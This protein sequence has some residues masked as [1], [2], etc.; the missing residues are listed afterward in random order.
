MTH[1]NPLILIALVT[2]LASAPLLYS[3]DVSVSHFPTG[4]E[5]P[6]SP[7][8]S[9]IRQR[10]T[11]LEFQKYN[12][13][14]IVREVQEFTPHFLGTASSEPSIKELCIEK[15]RLVSKVLCT[16]FEQEKAR[17]SMSARNHDPNKIHQRK[18]ARD[19]ASLMT[20]GNFEELDE[21]SETE[22]KLAIYQIYKSDKSFKK[23]REDLLASKQCLP[24][25]VVTRF[26]MRT[27]EDFPDP[28][29][30]K[31]A[32]KLYS[33]VVECDSEFSYYREIALFRGAMLKIWNNNCESA[34]TQL[35]ELAALKVSRYQTRSLYWLAY[36]AEVSNNPI[37]AEIY[38]NRLTRAN[39]LSYHSI[40]LNGG[41]NKKLFAPLSQT[42]PNIQFRSNSRSELNAY[43]TLI[44]ILQ[45]SG[46]REVTEELLRYVG[47]NL[48][49][50]ED[51][52]R[53]YVA[54]LQNR[55]GNYLGS[56]RTLSKLILNQPNLVTKSTL[57]LYYPSLEF[58]ELWKY[59]GNLN[60]Y[61]VSALIR[62]ESAFNRE[63]RSRVG[64]R[65]L[66]QLMPATAKRF[67]KKITNLGLYDPKTNINLG[68]RY[69][70]KLVERFNG[71]EDL[72]LAAYNAGPNKVD[73]W[74][75]RYPTD[76]K[77][78]FLD[79]IPYSETR[80]Y[81]SLIGRN[82][83]WY[84]SL[85]SSERLTSWKRERSRRGLAS[86]KAPLFADTLD[87]TQDF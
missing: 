18:N 78:L 52:F 54:V 5:L 83:Y 71:N 59:R 38:R 7:L 6:K 70:A 53:L 55:N 21:F 80:N 60:P 8:D 19:L 25:H 31:N 10:Q 42:E 40:V 9:V 49:N 30:I 85:Y 79:L 63:A 11:G 69:L 35:E 3:T 56:F 82:Y 87:A 12:L 4:G 45:E 67:Q 27:E 37:E 34:K 44:E 75:K 64:A 73:E 58:E 77:M 28:E 39:P 13:A 47:R 76:N 32:D 65:G 33:K 57:K 26:G 43:V 86:K 1:R 2:T 51:S 14:R 68:V 15:P 36:C 81:V 50:V 29:A 17:I 22:H 16:F 23:V 48:D 24:P 66:M 61:F 20:D 72:A 74:L 62:Q 84:L 46:E 41:E